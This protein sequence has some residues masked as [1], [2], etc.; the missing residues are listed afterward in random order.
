MIL[1]LPSQRHGTN[2]VVPHQ[3]GSLQS[4]SELINKSPRHLEKVDILK[5]GC[6]EMPHVVAS[7]TQN[8]RDSSIL[9][10]IVLMLTHTCHYTLAFYTFHTAKSIISGT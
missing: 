10:T 9:Q 3:A 4:R 5:R 7:M 1:R 2:Q 6:D 8:T